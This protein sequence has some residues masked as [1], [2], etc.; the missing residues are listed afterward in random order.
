MSVTQKECEKRE[1]YVENSLEG[2]LIG[3]LIG[4]LIG[5]QFGGGSNFVERSSGACSEQRELDVSMYCFISSNTC[6][7][8]LKEIKKV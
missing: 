5:N 6:C 8:N 2:S 7:R 1:V 3:D 4:G